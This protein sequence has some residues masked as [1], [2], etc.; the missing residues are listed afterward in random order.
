MN[1]EEHHI[2]HN[3]HQF[4]YNKSSFSN[5]N[6]N[7]SA[8]QNDTFWS[9]NLSEEPQP[10]HMLLMCLCPCFVGNPCSSV[11]ISDYKRLLRSFIF[12][13]TLV[14]IVYFIVELSYKGRGFAPVR[15]N[16]FLGPSANTLKELGAKYGPDIKYKY[17]IYRLIVPVFMHAGVIHII[18]NLWVQMILGLNCERSWG[19]IRMACIYLISGIAGNLMSCCIRPLSISVGASGAI[20]GIIGGRL[21]DIICRWWKL[22]QAEKILNLTSILFFL[23][24]NSAITFSTAIIDWSSHLGGFLAGFFLGLILFCNQPEKKLFKFLSATV[25]F[26]LIVSYFVGTSV[27]FA[28]APGP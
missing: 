24:F 13:V 1:E 4:Q 5:E 11:R 20:L 23:M 12:Y 16:P 10:Y 19:F 17:Q 21:S 25:G 22:S 7:N 27:G 15:Q 8:R 28:L 14:Q 6:K 2:S 26:L 3:H 9:W 18:M